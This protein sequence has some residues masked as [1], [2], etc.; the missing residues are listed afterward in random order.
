MSD[1]HSD[2]P[3]ETVKGGVVKLRRY[4]ITSFAI[5]VFLL[6]MAACVRETDT[7]VSEGDVSQTQAGA[8]SVSGESRTG[9]SAALTSSTTNGLTSI[10]SRPRIDVQGVGTVS[11]EPDLVE[12]TLGVE[13]RAKKVKSAQSEA[14]K[15]MSSIINI[16][17]KSG[18]AEKDIQTRYFDITDEY[19]YQSSKRVFIG[20]RVSNS[21]TAKIRDLDNVGGIIDAVVDAGGDATRVSNITFTV[22]ELAPYQSQA[23][24]LAVADAIAK[25]ELFADLAGVKRGGL[26]FITESGGS[27]PVS[28]SIGTRAYAYAEESIATPISVGDLE[29]EVTVQT[30]FDIKY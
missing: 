21:V 30:I 18:L 15:A 6:L 14:A 4:S 19:E 27:T 9:T 22:E 24:E 5:V 20:Y 17:E 26:V 25:A 7:L 29:V 10:S 12:L 16:L 8:V 28:Q 11:V 23:R 2:S 3:V 13:T 1:E